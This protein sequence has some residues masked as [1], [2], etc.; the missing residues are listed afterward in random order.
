M[1]FEESDK[2]EKYV[3]GLPDMIQGSVMESKPKTMQNEIEFATEL[4]DQKICTFAADRH[5]K[6]DCL[7]LKNKNQGIQAKNGKQQ[8]GLMLWALLKTCL[9]KSNLETYRLFETQVEFQ[10]DLIPGAP[11]VARAPYLLAPS[12]MKELSNQLHELSDKGFI[13]PSSSPW[14]ASILFVKKKDGLFRMCIDYR[15]LNKLTVKNHYP[16]LRI[17]DLFDTLRV[18]CLLEDRLEVELSSTDSS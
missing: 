14:E 8:Q 12:E 18:E 3:G 13:R 6:R 17:D 16:L 11:P 9:K 15:E 1:F 5:Y 2:V 10:I 4:M 7:K